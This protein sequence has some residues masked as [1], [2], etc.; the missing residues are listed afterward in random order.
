MTP[1]LAVTLVATVTVFVGAVVWFAWLVIQARRR[2][3]HFARS[4]WG[5]GVV[6]RVKIRKRRD[7]RAYARVVTPKRP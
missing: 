2:G 4:V 6:R 5:R 3:F 1:E 7:G